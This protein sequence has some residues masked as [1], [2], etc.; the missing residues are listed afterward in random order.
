MRIK[1]KKE[2]QVAILSFSKEDSWGRDRKKFITS[3][4]EPSEHRSEIIL[5]SAWLPRP[6]PDEQSKIRCERGNLGEMENKRTEKQIMNL[7]YTF[8]YNT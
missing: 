2:G 8:T 7:E 6:Q 3:I 1:D 4:L 5:T